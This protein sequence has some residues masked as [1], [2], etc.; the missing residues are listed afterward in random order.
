VTGHARST[1]TCAYCPKACRFA[2]PVSAAS[3]NETHSTWG[4]MSAAY[5]VEQH[6]RP[7][8]ADAALALHACTGCLRCTEVCAHRNQVAPALFEA[9]GLAL[10][11]GLQPEGAASTV[12]TF[13]RALNPFGVE[14][15]AHLQAFGAQGPAGAG[16]FPGCSALVKHP[17][18]VEHAL[19]VSA[20]F[21]AP[22]GVSPLAARC[23]GYPLYAAGA[24]QAFR[25]HARAFAQAAQDS[26]ELVVLDPG[27]AYTLQRLY[28]VF[29]VALPARTRTL[30]SVLLEHVRHAPGK[31]PLRLEVGYHDACHLGRGLGEYDGPRALVSRAA[32]RVHEAPSCREQGGCS[33]GGGLLPR[34]MPELAVQVARHQ[35]TELAAG[36]AAR[37]VV[38][39]C[40]SSRRLFD[41]AGT[42][43][44]D[45]VELL[46]RWLEA[47]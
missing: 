36:G 3:D 38:T 45:L 39:A 41:R 29:G 18:A 11:R 31:P 28:P 34:T 13:S 43:V 37:A 14:L 8:D 10:D 22:L 6:G 23:C 46:H 40:P 47:P 15:A 24:H 20:G 17:S 7:L 2:C 30:T 12:A 25:E 9:R 27:C 32:E 16:L 33:G 4:K 5:L 21:G 42:P 44:F 19:A 26:A 1:A 35:A